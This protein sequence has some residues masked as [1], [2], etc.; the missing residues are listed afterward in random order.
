MHS[1]L[2]D[3]LGLW[4]SEVKTQ[5]FDS[6]AFRAMGEITWREERSQQRGA[7]LIMKHKSRQRN[8]CVS[9]FASSFYFFWGEEGGR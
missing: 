4:R 9:R 5:I 1:K 3:N 6:V 2:L 7:V 8:T